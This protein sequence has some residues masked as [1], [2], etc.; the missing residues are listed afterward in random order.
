MPIKHLP[1][2]IHILR[3]RLR[4]LARPSVWLSAVGVALVLGVGWEYAKRLNSSDNTN[5]ETD[6]DTELSGTGSEWQGELSHEDAQIAAD[7][8][9]SDVLRSLMAEASPA[10]TPAS[11]S[12]QSNAAEARRENIDRLIERISSDYELPGSSSN[13][14][15][16]SDGNVFA[17]DLSSFGL[18]GASDEEEAPSQ[19]AAGSNFFLSPATER[20]TNSG[21][22]DTLANFLQLDADRSTLPSFGQNGRQHSAEAEDSAENPSENPSANTGNGRENNDTDEGNAAE[23]NRDGR[24][25]SAETLPLFATPA[26]FPQSSEETPPGSSIPQFTG[27]PYNP[28]A[29]VPESDDNSGNSNPYANPYGNLNLNGTPTPSPS[30]VPTPTYR[31]PTFGA[32][33]PTADNVN[34]YDNLNGNLN[35]MPTTG[36]PFSVNSGTGFSGGA[37]TPSAT[38]YAYPTAPPQQFSVPRTPPGRAIGNGEIN[39]FANP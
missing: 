37:T 11:G 22:N 25:T 17:L 3:A 32:T 20:D 31:R 21:E 19:D 26:P 38:P 27:Y 5:A 33:S 12:R 29:G 8:D 2:S 6:N 14:E 7:I 13:S 18:F 39:T 4:S 36:N 28:N 15:D 34:P 30:T 23:T 24:A 35:G 1:N 9:S 10:P 16:A